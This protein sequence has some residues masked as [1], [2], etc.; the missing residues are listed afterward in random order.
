MFQASERLAAVRNSLYPPTMG[1]FFMDEIL[2][3]VGS[4]AFPIVMCIAFFWRQYKSDEAYR[5]EMDALRDAHAE[6]SQQFTEALN[7]NTLALQRLSDKL[8]AMQK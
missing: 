5:Q 7:N 4:Y 8:E 6:E 2:T 1:G 3:L